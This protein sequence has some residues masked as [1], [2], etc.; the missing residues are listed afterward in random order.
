MY[1]LRCLLLP[2]TIQTKPSSVCKFQP[3]LQRLLIQIHPDA[4]ITP[5]TTVYDK[6]TTSVPLPLT[7]DELHKQ[8]LHQEQQRRQ[9]LTR[10]TLQD[11]QQCQKQLLRMDREYRRICAAGRLE[12]QNQQR[13]LQ[14]Q[15][16]E[17]QEEK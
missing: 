12:F 10:E 16:Q 6:Y 11:R 5:V 13:I 1:F 15:E 2:T 8:Y 14:Q 4:V 17:Q 7:S 3:L 9:Q